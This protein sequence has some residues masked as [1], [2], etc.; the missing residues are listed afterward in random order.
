MKEDKMLYQANKMPF[1]YMFHNAQKDK[2]CRH[3]DIEIECIKQTKNRLAKEQLN[4][5]NL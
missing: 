5:P 4:I 3:C 2:I 1:C